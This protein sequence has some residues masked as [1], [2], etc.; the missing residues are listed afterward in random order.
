MEL[1]AGVPITDYCDRHKLDP[2]E[3]LG[4]FVQVCHAVQH[5]HQKGVIHRDLKPS[6][7]MVTLHDAKR[8]GVRSGGGGEGHERPQLHATA[9][10]QPV[11][12]PLAV[13][14]SSRFQVSRASVVATKRELM[15]LANPWP[16]CTIA[17]NNP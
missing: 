1:V 10:L 6:N 9:R 5:A 11:P 12:R 14:V 15:S 3:R 7:V 16:R 17:T 8:L 4:L 13:L 2:R